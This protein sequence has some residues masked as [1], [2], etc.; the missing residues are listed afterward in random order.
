[1]AKQLADIAFS[2]FLLLGSIYLWFV[3]DSFPTFERYQNVDSDFWPK[4]LLI[5]SG[6]LAIGLCYQNIVA[7]LAYRKQRSLK[8]PNEKLSDE[9][10]VNWKKLL[11]VSLLVITYFAGLKYAGFLFSTVA[12]L[13]IAVHLVSYPNRLA[14]ALF[15]FVFTAMI[16]VIF[17]K[18]L[19]LPLPRGIGFF[20]DINLL[21][22]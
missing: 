4:A 13:S 9:N 5:I 12:F 16:I 17:A 2:L 6:L 11:L 15:P 18:T 21:F 8:T 19:S 22:Y 7:T 14:K 10:S 20:Y 3:A 1:M